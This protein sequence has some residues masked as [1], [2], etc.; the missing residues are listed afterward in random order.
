MDSKTTTS[1]PECSS[2]CEHKLFSTFSFWFCPKCKD[3][4]EAIRKKL[5]DRSDS[6]A[7]MRL[8]HGF[9]Y[10]IPL[11]DMDGATM[12]WIPS[13]NATSSASRESEAFWKQYPAPSNLPAGYCEY[14]YDSIR[15]KLYC[16]QWL[17]G[18]WEYS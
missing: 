18:K 13:S 9:I 7:T 8:D 17:D 15:L 6:Q 10:Q 3:D 4:V 1:C 16:R 2:A 12:N 11:I 5:K 14:K